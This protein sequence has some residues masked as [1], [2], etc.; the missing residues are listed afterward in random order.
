M[1]V[2]NQLEMWNNNAIEVFQNEGDREKNSFFDNISVKGIYTQ[3]Y[4][5][6]YIIDTSTLSVNTYP[7][8]QV[9]YIGE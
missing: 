8:W 2:I 4:I 9:L 5:C 1:Y 3:I 6:L 7:S